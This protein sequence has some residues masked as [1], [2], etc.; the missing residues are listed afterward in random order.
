M[1]K[2]ATHQTFEVQSECSEDACPDDAEFVIV[3]ID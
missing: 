1:T 3:A 2:K